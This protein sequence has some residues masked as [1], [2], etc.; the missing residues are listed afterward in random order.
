MLKEKRRNDNVL[1]KTVVE[2]NISAPGFS[3]WL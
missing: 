2:I 3:V 1:D